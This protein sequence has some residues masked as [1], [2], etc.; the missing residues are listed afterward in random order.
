[1]PSPYH[2]EHDGYAVLNLSRAGSRE[3]HFEPFNTEVPV[4]DIMQS[5]TH[6][7]TEHQAT[8]QIASLAGIH[9]D[10][11]AIEQILGNLLS[12]VIK[13]LEPGRPG[14]IAVTAEQHDEVTTFHVQDNGRGIAADDLSKVF[15]LFRRVGRQDTQGE[16]MGLTYVQTLV[17]RHGGEIW[18]KSTLGVGTTFTFTLSH[19]L[20]QGANT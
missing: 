8:V 5:L 3:L 13:Y 7:L 6:Q 20:A 19:E 4:Q 1:M 15:E 16:G 14:E 11:T 18:C 2:E 17:R 9:A 10:R 12:N